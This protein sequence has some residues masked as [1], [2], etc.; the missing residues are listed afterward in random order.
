MALSK[1]I[2]INNQIL[3]SYEYD[4][5]SYDSNSYMSDINNAYDAH[6][7]YVVTY[8]DGALGLIDITNPVQDSS[9]SSRTLSNSSS[10]SVE[11]LT[12]YWHNTPTYQ[13]FHDRDRSEYY[14]PGYEYSNDIDMN[15]AYGSYP[16]VSD[17][18]AIY[19]N[20]RLL[21][22]MRGSWIS[23]MKPLNSIFKSSTGDS[24]RI[25]SLKYDT[26][27]IYLI[28]GYMF[29]NI[30]GFSLRVKVKRTSGSGEEQYLNLLDFVF[31]KDRLKDMVEWIPNPLYMSSRFYDRCMTVRFLSPYFLSHIEKALGADPEVLKVSQNLD[32]HLE[33]ST[34]SSEYVN[35]ADSCI[36]PGKPEIS[37]VGTCTFN[38]DAHVEA[39]VRMNS[40]SDY[41]NAVIT[42]DPDNYDIVYYPTFGTLYDMRDL[43]YD[44]MALINSGQISMFTSGFNDVNS[45][46][47]S[48]EYDENSMQ[49]C[50]LNE[51]NVQYN[52]YYIP[53]NGSEIVQRSITDNRTNLIDYTGKTLADG[54]F[55]KTYYTPKIREYRDGEN[56]FD[57]KSISLNLVCHLVNR[58]NGAEVVRSVSMTIENP[59]VY[60]DKDKI[61]LRNIMTWKIFNKI[62]SSKIS[63]FS[64]SNEQKSQAINKVFYSDNSIVVQDGNTYLSQGQA[65]LRLFKNDHYYKFNLYETSSTNTRMPYTLNGPYDYVLKLPSINGRSIE[66]KPT[67]SSNMNLGFGQIEFKITQAQAKQA[68]SVPE[69]DRYFAIVCKNQNLEMSSIYQ[70]NIAWL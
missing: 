44:I 22:S 20:W 25:S 46:I 5:Y 21:D 2:Q 45:E 19:P 3:L 14:W 40:N 4:N 39:E 6:K 24:V 60:L 32:I 55:W 62:E 67:Y 49:W 66:I 8:M 41:F 42:Q 11:S 27:K 53:E 64:R 15:H 29:D 17:E 18:D 61:S 68:M 43:D 52:Y 35:S 37:L 38:E 57:I 16:G 70:G 9:T 59:E 26:I 65:T 36:I 47:D 10:V 1:Y 58:M 63:Q 56:V 48:Y 51:L 33:F 23:N 13:R 12:S 69:A 28:S 50:I 7:P 31:F 34:I 30:D 54:E